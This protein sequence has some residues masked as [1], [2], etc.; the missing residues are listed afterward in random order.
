[1]RIIWLLALLSGLSFGATRLPG[2]FR[3]KDEPSK[4]DWAYFMSQT[5]DWRMNLWIYHKKVGDSFEHWNWAWRLGWIK[6]CV[7]AKPVP[8]CSEVLSKAEKDDALVVRNELAKTIGS[9]YAESKNPKAAQTLIRLFQDKRN[10]L[11]DK[12]TFIHETILFSLKQI[13]DTPSLEAAKKLAGKHPKLLSYI[14]K[15]DKAG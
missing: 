9:K 8:Y 15:I 2:E 3:P 12:P 10:F 5:V 13:G 11:G 14:Q 6:T 1:M 4:E 7:T